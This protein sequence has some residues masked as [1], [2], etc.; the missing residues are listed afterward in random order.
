MPSESKKP[1][2]VPE[3]MEV[4]FLGLLRRG[5][6]WTAR[7]T[8]EVEA[9]QEAHLANISRMTESGE[10]IAAG[11]FTDEGDLRGVY[12]FRVGSLNEA[13]LL[14]ETDP[15]VKAGRLQFELH[16]WWVKKGVF[17]EGR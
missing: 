3:G 15:A 9:L 17:A 2:A 14:T 13:I 5:P 7:E 6:N 10:L 8:P 4:L 12:I 16:P 11:P 1:D